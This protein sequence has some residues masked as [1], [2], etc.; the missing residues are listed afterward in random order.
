MMMMMMNNM[1][2]PIYQF[3]QKELPPRTLALI[4]G[5]KNGPSQW[6]RQLFPPKRFSWR[7][8]CHVFAQKIGQVNEVSSKISQ[9]NCQVSYLVKLTSQFWLSIT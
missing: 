4:V 5:P 3:N 8:T 1:E 9:V 2:Y 7:M 6:S